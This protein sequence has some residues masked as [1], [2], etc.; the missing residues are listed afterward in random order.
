METEKHWRSKAHYVKAEN[1]KELCDKFTE[2]SKD[3]F[4]VAWQIFTN[5]SMTPINAVVTY[6][7]Q[8]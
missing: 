7:E 5:A 4:V 1:F 6:K 8:Q 2:F 3:K